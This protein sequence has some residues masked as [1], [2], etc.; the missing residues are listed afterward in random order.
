MILIAQLYEGHPTFFE[1][2]LS[3]L[4]ASKE[5]EDIFQH[6]SSTT[7]LLK[8]IRR[9]NPLLRRFCPLLFFLFNAVLIIVMQ[10]ALLFAKGA[11]Y[12]LR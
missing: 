2:R 10:V 8:E 7:I 3:L 11:V 5:G 4:P 6:C 9:P 12:L 1:N